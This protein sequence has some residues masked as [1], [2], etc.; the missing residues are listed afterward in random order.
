MSTSDVQLARVAVI[1]DA[2][3]PQPE[4]DEREIR[5]VAEHITTSPEAETEATAG[6]S[7]TEGEA[8]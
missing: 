1:L 8:A 2:P 6:T 3:R 7:A 4:P 5:A